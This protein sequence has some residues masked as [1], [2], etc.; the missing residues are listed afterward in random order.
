[1]VAKDSSDE[2]AFWVA[3]VWQSQQAHQKFLKL[4]SVHNDTS[5]DKPMI[6]GF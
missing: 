5:K 3:E 4:E 6:A 1:V 2:D